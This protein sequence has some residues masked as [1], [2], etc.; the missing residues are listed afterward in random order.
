MLSRDFLYL[1]PAGTP[2]VVVRAS[3]CGGFSRFGTR[4]LEHRLSSCGARAQL[5]CGEWTLH[6]GGVE[7][8]PHSPT[9]ALTGGFLST[10]PPG[11]SSHCYK[12]L[13]WDN[14]TAYF[15]PFAN[16]IVGSMRNL[17]YEMDFSDSSFTPLNC[18]CYC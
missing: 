14:F 1:R 8:M 9:P 12:Q 10:E 2:P 18:Y 7:P 17:A 3:H 11:K 13:S 15:Y 6:R 16:E 5:P 4:A